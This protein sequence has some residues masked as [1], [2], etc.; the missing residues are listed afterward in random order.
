MGRKL[1]VFL[2]MVVFGWG[3]VLADDIH[4][5]IKK[6]E[7]Q[8]T[9]V[10]GIKEVESLGD[11]TIPSLIQLSE[12]K[13]KDR[14]S[15]VAAIILLGRVKKQ[16]VPQKSQMSLQMSSDD[17]KIKNSLETTMAT[18]QDAFCR[19]ASALTLGNIGNKE[20]IPKLKE[21]LKD[22]AGNVRMRAV[23]A[24][25]KC[26]DKSGKELAVEALRSRDVTEQFLAVEALETIGDKEIIPQLKEN[27]KNENVWT[28]INSQLAIKR[29]EIQ[30]LSGDQRMD[31][32]KSSLQDPQYEVNHWSS[33]ELAKEI[34]MNTTNREKSLGILKETSKDSKHPGNYSATKTLRILLSEDVISEKELE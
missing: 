2:L 29:I 32:L 21:A 33:E 30:G 4:R 14:D 27:L 34:R 11:K 3:F 13:E 26:G 17:Q 28:M 19:E 23:W 20:S 15:R 12:D 7:S 16:K 6:L 10:E 9:R 25:A 18:D 8:A 5:A 24:M 31:Y 1:I 22:S